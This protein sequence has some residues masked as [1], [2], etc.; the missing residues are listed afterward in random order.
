[1]R[2]KTH[3]VW[4]LQDAIPIRTA[5]GR[6]VRNGGGDLS[7]VDDDPTCSACQATQNAY[8]SDTWATED[9]HYKPRK[10]A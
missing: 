2:R 1:M 7:Y 3:L 8:A 4:R 6:P 9:Y 10:E 5:C